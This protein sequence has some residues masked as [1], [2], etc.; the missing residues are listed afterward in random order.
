MMTDVPIKTLLHICN[1]LFLSSSAIDARPTNKL[2][3]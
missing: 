1:L 3:Y 2:I